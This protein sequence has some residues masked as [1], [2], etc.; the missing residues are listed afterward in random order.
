[1]TKWRM[2]DEGRVADSPFVS[3]E[4]LPRV[5]VYTRQGCHLCEQ[6]EAVVA[7][8]CEELGERFVFIDI[9]QDED[10]QAR[11]TAEVPVTL[12]DGAQHDFWK[13]DA[14]RLRAALSATV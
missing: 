5:T 3:T 2:A 8:V 7:A 13:V 12:V 9:D 1:M 14:D 11:Y 4:P 6:A 10:L